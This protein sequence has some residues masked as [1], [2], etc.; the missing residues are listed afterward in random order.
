MPQRRRIGHRRSHLPLGGVSTGAGSAESPAFRSVLRL[1]LPAPAP[2]L[3]PSAPCS[4]FGKAATT[5]PVI[6][7]PDLLRIPKRRPDP[8]PDFARPASRTSFASATWVASHALAI[9]PAPFAS[10]GTFRARSTPSAATSAATADE[11]RKRRPQPPAARPVAWRSSATRRLVGAA[12][13]LERVGRP[14]DLRGRV[15][16][17]RDERAEAAHVIGALLQQLRRGI[18]RASC[19]RRPC[20]TPRRAAATRTR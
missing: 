3:R 7:D 10:T 8:R 6:G 16:E 1:R 18:V 2:N 9:F 14:P 5:R 20:A 11:P 19:R 12:G 17:R 4:D 15:V 13:S